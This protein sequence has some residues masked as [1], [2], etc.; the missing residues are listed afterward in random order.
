MKSEYV[1]SIAKLIFDLVYFSKINYKLTNNYRCG[2]FAN[3]QR[4]LKEQLIDRSLIQKHI[5]H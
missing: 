3:F 1:C 4:E 5:P 2:A